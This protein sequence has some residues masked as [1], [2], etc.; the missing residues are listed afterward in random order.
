[1]YIY[2]YIYCDMRDDHAPGLR[3]RSAVVARTLISRLL[4]ERC[5]SFGYYEAPQDQAEPGLVL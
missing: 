5:H 4:N 1:M 3:R 2:I